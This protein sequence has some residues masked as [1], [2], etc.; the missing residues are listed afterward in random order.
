[1]AVVLGNEQ[2]HLSVVFNYRFCVRSFLHSNTTYLS[3]LGM[4]FSVVSVSKA[5]KMGT[6]L[7]TMRR[8]VVPQWLTGS[9]RP[10][11]ILYNVLKKVD[12]WPLGKLH[13]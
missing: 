10:L 11:P 9:H 12:S 1:M 2:S 6:H 4:A 5:T 8:D 7:L 3:G 13:T